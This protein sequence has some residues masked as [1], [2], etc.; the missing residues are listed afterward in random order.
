MI[1]R[2]NFYGG[3]G[4][5]KSTS[6]AYA[7]YYLKQ[8]YQEKNTELVQ[9]FVKEW[10]WLGRQPTG[11]D[12]V[13]LFAQQ[14][15]KEETLLKRNVDF[16]IS[17]SPVD[18]SLIYGEGFIKESLKVIIDN[19][20]KEYP[21]LNIFIRRGG[22][23]FNPCGRFQT[24]KEAVEFDNKILSVLDY[25]NLYLVDYN[26]LEQIKDIIERVL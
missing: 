25:K 20:E 4:S 23:I 15:H 17:D 2:I 22:K 26:N 11:Y 19:Y 12:Q 18:L 3:P 9:E 14:L 21:S 1:R 6:A 5:G 13:Y 7:F 10:A 24:Y 16:V 8:Y